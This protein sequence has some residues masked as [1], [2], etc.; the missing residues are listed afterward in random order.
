MMPF[1]HEFCSD[2]KV[3]ARTR[4]WHVFYDGRN[5]EPSAAAQ[6]DAPRTRR[7]LA[8]S[9]KGGQGYGKGGAER[10][11]HSPP[12]GWHTV[13]FKCLL[14]MCLK[15]METLRRTV[16][17]N[18]KGAP[19]I[20]I[21]CPL[22]RVAIPLAYIVAKMW[23]NREVSVRLVHGARGHD[24]LIVHGIRHRR[25][26]DGIPDQYKGVQADLARE[27]VMLTRGKLATVMWLEHEPQ[28]LPWQQGSTGLSDQQ[29]L[30]PSAIA[31]YARKR[32]EVLRDRNMEWF[33]L[34]GQDAWSWQEI[35]NW[36]FWRAEGLGTVFLAEN[37]AAAIDKVAE[38]LQ[39]ELKTAKRDGCLP[40]F[41]RP[42]PQFPNI[43]SLFEQLLAGKEPEVEELQFGT[44]RDVRAKGIGPVM[45]KFK[46]DHFDPANADVNFTD[47][48]LLERAWAFGVVSMPC[49][50]V[51]LSS[52]P[53][54]GLTTV[55]LPFIFVPGDRL[56][57]EAVIEAL[58]VLV[59][60]VAHAA[61]P[62][63]A[64]WGAEKLVQT[65]HKAQWKDDKDGMLWFNKACGSTRIA[66]TIVDI[67]KKKG[68]KKRWYA[69]LGGGAVD[70]DQSWLMQGLVILAKDWDW[71]ACTLVALWL[72]SGCSDCGRPAW[73]DERLVI[74]GDAAVEEPKEHVV[75]DMDPE[76]EAGQG[77]SRAVGDD[78]A[79]FR[80]RCHSI[81]EKVHSR[82]ADWP[83]PLPQG[84]DLGALNEVPSHGPQRQL[85]A[86]DARTKFQ[87]WW[88]EATAAAVKEKS[89]AEAAP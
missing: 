17:L 58:G 61:C 30:V 26:M 56:D 11:G 67:A 54:G 27:Y 41:G 28:G 72:L 40:T 46:P 33:N 38:N 51:T 80:A 19:F 14:A 8:Q 34:T 16:Q 37:E 50:V 1:A 82:L 84:D 18:M 64:T 73:V 3:A 57:V 52:K 76:A 47:P 43:V 4:L 32:M 24:A 79:V 29:R 74:A 63:K 77:K 6:V 87:T 86:Q 78:A 69:Y 31:P 65:P 7:G 5:W 10:G 25:R 9:S 59:W 66:T 81:A 42:V 44:L 85:L 71:A 45:E 75:A 49:P 83:Y 13:L 60:H 89:E 88:K 22:A 15:Q 36:N 55:C 68:K 20:M 12:V 48:H 70:N 23:P 62:N 2:E 39:E 21:V 35:F 53:D